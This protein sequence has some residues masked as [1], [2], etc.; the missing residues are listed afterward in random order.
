MPVLV[1]ASDVESITGL[2][3]RHPALKHPLV[4]GAVGVMLL[5]ATVAVLTHCAKPSN[6]SDT[7]NNFPP[8]P[9]SAPPFEET[10]PQYSE[11]LRGDFN[12]DGR[13]DLIHLCCPDYAN[14]WFGQADGSFV[15]GHLLQHGSGY[16][17][18]TGTWLVGAS[19][20]RGAAT[21]STCVVRTTRT[22]GSGSPT[23]RSHRALH[24]DDAR[25]G[26][27]TGS[28]SRCA[29][30]RSRSAPAARAWPRW[31]CAPRR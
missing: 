9:C 1:A 8:P 24:S 16:P 12:G 15:E 13:Q 23:V 25:R 17:M 18:Q 10:C 30:T 7:G 31:A 2:F 28:R 27:R 11:G 4:L 22:F 21:S 26:R 14:V 29:G 6:T 5:G 19:T 3:S 20:A